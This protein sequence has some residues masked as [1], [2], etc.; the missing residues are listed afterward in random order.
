MVRRRKAA[1]QFTTRMLLVAITA[2]AIFIGWEVKGVRDRRYALQEI[3][4]QGGDF[5]FVVSGNLEQVQEGRE[6]FK[7][8]TVRRLIG[9]REVY[10]I[11]FPRIA[12]ENDR[13]LAAFFP[14]ATVWANSPDQGRSGK[15]SELYDDGPL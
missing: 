13:R 11:Y 3:E 14:E 8:S 7:L 1:Y 10:R 9:D 2:S 15:Q 5:P 4:A 6:D 12:T